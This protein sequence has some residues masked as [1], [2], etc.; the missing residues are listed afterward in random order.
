MEQNKSSVNLPFHSFSGR[1]NGL[2]PA[3]KEPAKPLEFSRHKELDAVVVTDSRL[4]DIILLNGKSGE[5]QVHED[6]KPVQNISNMS[7]SFFEV[8]EE[9]ETVSLSDLSSSFR[10]CCQ[11]T[12]KERKATQFRKTQ[13]PVHQFKPFDYEAARKQAGYEDRR[14]NRKE[15]G[16]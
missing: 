9:D 14:R 5:E 3:V 11:S 16:W 13:E 8:D 1:A 4:Q 15:R 2:Q 10:K 12:H 6:P 7:A